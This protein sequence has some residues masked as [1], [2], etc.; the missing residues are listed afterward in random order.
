[1]SVR[2]D[3]KPDSTWQNRRRLRLHGLLVITLVV[4]GLSGSLLAYIH[5][6]PPP[7]AVQA[8]P[9]TSRQ[10]AAAKPA[11]IPPAAVPAFKPKYEFYK[12]L[13]E[14]QLI[15]ANEEVE[16]HA[17]KQN[18]PLLPA[19][20][21]IGKAS[22][23]S[24]SPQSGGASKLPDQ[25]TAST[26]KTGRYILHAGSFRNPA[27]AD[28]RKA[29]LL[30]LGV[31]AHIETVTGTDGGKMHRVR[32]GPLPDTEAKTLRQRLQEHRIHVSL[33]KSAD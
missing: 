33:I 32:V 17:G 26:R 12:V 15:I 29:T 3:Y 13:P 9:P 18:Q 4:I 24:T 28:E 10:A 19:V 5:G 25:T 20:E 30:A 22:R 2:R 31:P 11:D 16:Q 21:L 7:S 14:R 23:P 8:K 1:V 27:E 6:K